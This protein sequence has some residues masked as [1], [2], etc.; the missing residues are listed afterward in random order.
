M[1]TLSP[2]MTEGRIVAWKIRQ[3]DPL[4]AF[5]LVCDVET[6]SLT[7]HADE[8]FVLE[9]ESQEDGHVARLLVE[10]GEVPAP[11]DL[12]VTRDRKYND[13]RL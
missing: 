13:A 11:P 12:D 10:E 8:V 1:P 9:V 6:A 3:G 5:Q 7:E 2:L 4:K